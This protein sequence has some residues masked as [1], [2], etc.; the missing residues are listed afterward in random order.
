[1]LGLEGIIYLEEF[2]LNRV[3]VEVLYGCF[4]DFL[5]ERRQITIVSFEA[6]QRFPV[7]AGLF[8][9]FPL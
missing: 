1:M 3:L 5:E 6:L 9:Q 7:V 2:L 4:I 8:V